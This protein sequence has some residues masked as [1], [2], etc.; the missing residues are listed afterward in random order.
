MKSSFRRRKNH[1]ERVRMKKI[2]IA[3]EDLRK[4]FSIHPYFKIDRG[5]IL[6]ITVRYII[7]LEVL[8]CHLKFHNQTY[9]NE[10]EYRII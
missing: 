10:Y 3:F 7:Y 5:S 1:N 9:L 6:D 8:L 4:K 2:I